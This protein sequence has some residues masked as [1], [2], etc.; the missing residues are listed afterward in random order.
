MSDRFLSISQV[1][2]RFER[3]GIVN[4]VLKDINLEVN[5]GE[6]ISLIGHLD[7]EGSIC[8]Q[9]TRPTCWC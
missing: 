3:N 7:W 8:Q 2:M 1:Q 6:Y 4:P 5:R 9:S